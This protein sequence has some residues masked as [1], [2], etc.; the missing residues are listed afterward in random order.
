MINPNSTPPNKTGSLTE[1]IILHQ[2]LEGRLKMS[3]IAKYHSL[4]LATVSKIMKRNGYVRR[5]V[6]SET[7]GKAQ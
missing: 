7:A 4:S 1:A 5:W 2:V 3:A 6:K